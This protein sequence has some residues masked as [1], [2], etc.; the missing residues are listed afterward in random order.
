MKSEEYLKESARTASTQFHTEIV[1]PAMLEHILEQ[2]I[3]TG[4]LVDIAKKSLFY[5]KA[6]ESGS[7]IENYKG[8]SSNINPD[9]VTPEILHAALG[10]YTEAAE[11]LEAILKAMRGEA[12]D[13]V[14][15]FEEAGDTEWY[16]AMMYRALN[17]LP[18]EA[19]EINIKKLRQRY[20]EKF[21]SGQAISRN[22]EAEREIL[23]AG[24]D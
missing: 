1:E 20:P 10:V 12:F 21:D 4:E 5:G 2:A 15:M 13:E 7:D 9:A 6:I 8:K 3:K 14:N 16:M 19:R 18:A 24:T 11:M 17:R 23:E 22:L